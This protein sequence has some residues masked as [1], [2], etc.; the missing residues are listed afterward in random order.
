M[1][2]HLKVGVA[3]DPKSTIRVHFEVDQAS[4]RVLIGH[5]GKHLP[6]PGR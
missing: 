2:K 6:L 4:R 5:C 1:L 3:D